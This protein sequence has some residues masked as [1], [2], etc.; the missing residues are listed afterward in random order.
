MQFGQPQGLWLGLAAALVLLTY[1]VRRRARRVEVPFLALWTGA[2]SER[3]GGFGGALTRWLDLLLAML[4]CGAVAVAAGAPFLPGVDSTVRD[5]VLVIDG[6]VELRAADR[7]DR[8]VR[9]AHAEVNRRARGS[10]MLI[11]RVDPEGPRF[12]VGSARA[13]AR[14]FVRAHEGGWRSAEIEP[15]LA[16]AREGARTLKDPD[17]VFCTYR[18][19]KADG[20]R[21]RTVREAAPNAGF[22]GLEVVG[23]PEGGGRMAR[24][25]VEA[26]GSVE[27]EGLWRGEVDGRKEL[28][29]PLPPSGDVTLKL[30]ADN[31]A[32]AVDDV[33]Y[34]QLAER[35][36]PRVLVVADGEPSPFLIS[37]MRALEETRAIRG[38]LDR[39]VPERVAEV[40]ETYDVVLFDR[41]APTGAVPGMRALYI[42]PKDGALPFRVGPETDA[43]ALF[44]VKEDHAV[45]R[46]TGIGRLPPVRARALRGGTAL[47][48]AAPGPVIATGPGW[49]A[50]GY[51]PEGCVLAS[52]PAYPLFLRNCIAELAGGAPA[53]QAEFVRIGERT[54]LRG[55]VRTPDG[56]REK[57]GTRWN[58]PPG[59]WAQEENRIAVNFL[60]A[61]LDFEAA[62]DPSD[63]LEPVGTPA[64]PDEPLT[65]LFAAAAFVFLL[66]G[67]WWFWR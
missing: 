66:A 30:R 61:G 1:L 60:E 48:A 47:A 10:R 8:L 21:L 42:G 28:D 65:P 20:F 7:R 14:R 4:A 19:V 18:P 34:L 35:R 5:L 31:D 63:P 40:I 52:S 9:I 26:A 55:V 29:F 46:G 39:T 49:I 23:D 53:R 59:F 67:W 38:P 32:F 57:I 56:R 58:G 11:V 50:L 62:R 37:A 12:F 51:D 44:S 24:V 22:V 41:C 36:R 15:A 17:L 6:G 3:R 2:L 43:P 54:T 27:I 13:D 64:V 33:L 45:L 16:L 25:R